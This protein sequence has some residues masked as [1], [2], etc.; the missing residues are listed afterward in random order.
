MNKYIVENR[1]VDGQVVECK[2]YPS[3]KRRGVQ[4]VYCKGIRGTG[5][6]VVAEGRGQ[7]LRCSVCMCKISRTEETYGGKC[8]RCG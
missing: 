4:Y 5:G 1:V 7:I 2:V 8:S 3:R 6:L